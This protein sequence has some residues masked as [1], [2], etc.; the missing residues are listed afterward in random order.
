MA[1]T[2]TNA[3][4]MVEHD[5][6]AITAEEICEGDYTVRRGNYLMAI[7][8]ADIH[9]A[10]EC[11]FTIKRIDALA[12]ASRYLSLDRPEVGCRIG[13]E[14]VRR[15]GV[16]GQAKRNA[17]RGRAAERRTTQGV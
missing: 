12:E 6:F 14:P 16:A 5:S 3:V 10:V 8:A 11:A 4:T 7:V 13:T 2:C 1:V 15:G 9:A 17:D